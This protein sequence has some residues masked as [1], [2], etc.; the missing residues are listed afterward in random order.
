MT[1]ASISRRLLF[2]LATSERFE[3]AVRLL[4]PVENATRT[5]ASRYVAGESAEDALSLA[6]ELDKQGI[7]ASI[8][9]FGE[10]VSQPDEA[11][12]A[13]DAYVSLAERLTGA[14]TTTTL[15]LDLSHIGLDVSEPFCHEQLERIVAALPAGRRIDIGAE[16]S[17]RTDRALSVVTAVARAGAPVE[18][19]L[20]ANL[21]RSTEDWQLLV[22]AGAA[23]RLVKGAYVEPRE[24]AWS[25]G[26]ETD[27]AYVRLAHEL[28][29]ACASLA[30]GTHDPVLREAL[31]AAVGPLDIEMLLGVRRADADA[32][33]ARGV[34][35]RFY[36]PYGTGWFRYWMRRVA[37][38]MGS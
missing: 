29:S 4:P 6:G 14:P 34:P 30:L 25:Y 16:D 27:I 35:V 7:A 31:L 12:R 20:Q 26:E 8:D 28:K 9:F 18:M 11:R 17:A 33:V 24:L 5:A 21:K 1:T 3:T 36:V 15:A 38:A 37:E 10:Q 19:T 32:L 2:S 22:E 13:T 23:I